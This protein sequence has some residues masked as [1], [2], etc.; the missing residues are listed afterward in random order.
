MTLEEKL[1]ALKEFQLSD[2][3]YEGCWLDVQD[4]TS[5]F[6]VAK[7]IGIENGWLSVNFDGWSHKFDAK[8]KATSYK[9]AAFRSQNLG[10]TGQV[11]VSIR[12]L[13]PTLDL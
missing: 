2:F 12:P 1:Q 8:V 5:K 4:T 6:C 10:Y 11:R 13:I 3:I 7:V 9:V